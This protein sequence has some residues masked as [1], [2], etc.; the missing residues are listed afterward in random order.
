MTD[1]I[2][3]Q[4][5]CGRHD[6]KGYGWSRVAVD[7]IVVTK[8]G[9]LRYGISNVPAFTGKPWRGT[10]MSA[11]DFILIPVNEAK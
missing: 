9:M 7:S 11:I 8:P 5:I 10:W 3:Y 1:S 4:E 2:R 6:G